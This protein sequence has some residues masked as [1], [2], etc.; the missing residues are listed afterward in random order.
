MV[1][2]LSLYFQN[3]SSLAVDFVADSFSP[4]SGVNKLH[5][6]MSSSDISPDSKCP[7]CLD[8]F[9]NP[10]YL[11]YCSH[12]FCF[13]CVQEW[14]KT[15]AECPLC[16][17][18]FL[19]IVHSMRSEDDFQVYTVRPDNGILFE[20]GGSYRD[21][22]VEF[23]RSNPSFIHSLVPWLKWELTL[24]LGVHGSRVNIVQGIIMRNVTRYDL[25]SPAF[26][27]D[28]RP[29]LRHYTEHFLHEFIGYIRR[30]YNIEAYDLL[31]YQ[32][33][34]REEGSRSEF[35]IITISPDD[36]GSQ[37]AEQ[38]AFATDIGQA[39]WDDETP[40]PSYLSSEQLRAALSTTLD[41]SES[42]DEEPSTNARDL[43][44]PLPAP[45]EINEDS[46][47]SSDNCVIVGYVKPLA[48]RT[49]EVVELSSDSE[50]SID[51][52]KSEGVKKTKPIQYLSFSDRDA[53]GHASHSH[54]ERH[55]LKSKQKH[56]S[57][58]KWKKKKDG[59]KHKNKKGKKRS[60]AHDLYYYERRSRSRSRS[61]SHS[62][63]RGCDRTRSE[64]PSG[65]RKHKTHHLDSNTSERKRK[66]RSRS[67]SVEIIYERKPK[68]KRK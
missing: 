5:Q 29:F 43:Q 22:S 58:E 44:A 57:T 34:S 1:M 40:G 24:L 55:G 17:Q 32:A 39:P 68:K 28:L 25:D 59:S 38:N 14:S 33:P 48:K 65:K 13:Q 7:I 20:A 10:A 64:K 26:A 6:T 36:V 50:E 4:R 2:I 27:D 35:S 31:D 47:D 63:P 19:S 23:F 3:F 15:K 51:D 67:P 54:G 45:V 53:S 16:K 12:R 11:D 62:P 8:R 46:C 61:R 30:P 21:L 9:E 56:H 18:P 60:R 37:Q 49:P 52:G 41:T 42:S 66:R